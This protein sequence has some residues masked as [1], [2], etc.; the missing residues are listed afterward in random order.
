MALTKSQLINNQI[1]TPVRDL[2]I[3]EELIPVVK[4]RPLGKF[5]FLFD[6]ETTIYTNE[7]KTI[8]AQSKGNFTL[9]PNSSFNLRYSKGDVVDVVKIG[10]SNNGIGNI[11][12]NNL[13][14]IDVPKFVKPLC[15]S[16]TIATESCPTPQSYSPTITIDNSLGWLKKVPDTTPATLKLGQN[17]GNNPFPKVVVVNPTPTPTPTP[18]D[19]PVVVNGV[20]DTTQTESFFDDKNNLLMIAGVLLIGYLLLNDKSE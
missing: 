11:I 8:M 15:T 4:E 9:P 13:K 10:V 5:V 1:L 3:G 7:A 6:Y 2:E 14:I 18:T 20:E 16:L 19:T 12:N 17:F